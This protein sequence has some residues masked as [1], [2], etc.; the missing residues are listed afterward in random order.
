MD[1]FRQKGAIAE[2]MSGK[3]NVAKVVD[4]LGTNYLVVCCDIGQLTFEARSH[5]KSFSSPT[6]KEINFNLW[7]WPHIH[8]IC[9]V[10]TK[11]MVSNH[12]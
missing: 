10:S 12:K 5:K 1:H 11:F 2:T 6:E 8:H 7:S 4:S 9:L 3:D